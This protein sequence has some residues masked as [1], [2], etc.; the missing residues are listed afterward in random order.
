MQN[1]I[2]ILLTKEDKTI[3]EI[4][5][6][7]CQLIISLNYSLMLDIVSQGMWFN[8]HYVNWL[9]DHINLSSCFI[10]EENKALSLY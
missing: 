7:L 2:P 9:G 10:Q 6:K 1:F 5:H 8:Y 3:I 4:D